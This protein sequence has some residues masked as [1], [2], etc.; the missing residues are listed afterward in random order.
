MQPEELGEI[1][2][3]GPWLCHISGLQGKSTSD[4]RGRLGVLEVNLA[5]DDF[6]GR[7]GGAKAVPG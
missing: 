5:H 4:D 2:L 6:A 7:V 3:S 1:S